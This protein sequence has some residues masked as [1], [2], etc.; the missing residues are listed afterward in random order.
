M[1]RE[2]MGGGFQKKIRNNFA[3]KERGKEGDGR[4]ELPNREQ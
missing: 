2:K 4:K 1:K 3:K